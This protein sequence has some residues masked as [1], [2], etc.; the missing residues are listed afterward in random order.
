MCFPRESLDTATVGRVP[1]LTRS[2][3]L[4]DVLVPFVDEFPRCWCFPTNSYDVSFQTLVLKFAAQRQVSG[5]SSGKLR[6]HQASHERARTS[7]VQC[8][9][10]NRK[11]CVGYLTPSRLEP[12]Q[13]SPR[14]QR[15]LRGCS[16]QC[17]ASVGAIKL[18]ATRCG[19]VQRCVRQLTLG[20]QC[21]A[22]CMSAGSRTLHQVEMFK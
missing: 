18:E 19:P 5:T 6:N 9:G 1:T 2:V 8:C 4:H 20:H 13:P 12:L 21:L 11:G 22:T 16:V 7:V 17:P 14:L 10:A 3:A 15:G